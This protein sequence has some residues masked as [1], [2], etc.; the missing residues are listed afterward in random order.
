MSQRK[1]RVLIL[2]HESLVPPPGHEQMSEAEREDIRTESDVLATCEALGH[3]VRVVGL[4]DELLPLRRA[5]DEFQPHVA[6]NLL[7]EFQ[8]L[9]V[10]DHNVVSYLELMRVPYTGCNPRGLVLGR[11]KAV[12]KKILSYH[13]IP[14]PAFA[15][16][17]RG[18][19]IRPPK[20]LPYPVIVKSLTEDAS[21]GIAQASVVH[22]PDKLIERVEFIHRNVK[23]PAIAEQYIDGREVY[24][25]VL[26]DR[27]LTVLTPWELFLDKLPADAPKI[28]TRRAK[29]DRAY[30]ERHDIYSGPALDLGEETQRVLERRAKRI[31]RAL[32]LSGYARLDFRIDGKG[33]A[34]FLEANP[35]PELAS[36]AEMAYSANA[37]GMTYAQLI[38]RILSLGQRSLEL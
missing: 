13:R 26:G 2:C 5:I 8:G 20:H 14:V 7:E 12:S 11:D 37:S 33:E 16:F 29:W 35:N 3:E 36:D 28:A 27:R 10:Y 17:R 23:T 32:N 30:Q 24:V 1:L 18:R 21:V 31:Y 4:Y 9:T 38:A 6:V 25:G 15:T 19:K 22:T 34:W